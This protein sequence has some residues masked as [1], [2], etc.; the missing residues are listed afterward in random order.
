MASIATPVATERRAVDAALLF[1]AVF[2][3]ALALTIGL[4]LPGF[5]HH[6]T[7][8]AVMWAQGGWEAGFWKHPPF[9]PW[10]LRA[11]SS[12]APISAMSLSVLTAIN[13]TVC[14]WAVWMIAGMAV[15][16]TLRQVGSLAVLLLAALPFVSGM[17]IKLNHNSI[18]ISLWPLTTLAFLR[19]LDQP[20]ALRGALFGL[21]AAA[22]MLAKYYSGL[23]LA[24]CVVA[25]FATPWRARRF[26]A[27]PAP[28]VAIV[29]FVLAMAPHLAWLLQHR[30]TSL[31]YA[32]GASTGEIASAKRGPGMVLPFAVQTPLIAA[33][34]LV[35]AWLFRRFGAPSEVS[36]TPHRFEREIVILTLLP[37]VLTI[38]LTLGFNLRGAIAWAMPVFACLPA[39][40]AARIGALSETTL[41]NAAWIAAGLLIATIAVGQIALR[42]AVARGADGISDPRRKIAELATSAWHGATG[43]PLTIVAGDPRLSSASVVFSPDHPLGWPSFNEAQAP[44]IDKAAVMRDGF[45]ALCRAADASCLAA[46]AQRGGG[47]ELRCPLKRRITHLGA[48]GPWF[49]AV[50]VLIPPAGADK[51]ATAACPPDKP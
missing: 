4:R 13:M 28:Y 38:A 50:V 32:F 19:A 24:G 21:I 22:A 31:T 51:P 1:A 37:Y 17:A 12:A 48:V 47:R 25:S 45:V 11:W 27:A 15:E 5:V 41:K 18:L 3:G 14:A 33:P 40:L 7:T 42:T 8:E 44:W 2:C 36:P 49:E 23:L 16:R 10:V 34:M 9:L 43:R 6:D 20:T 46:A 39:V 26:Y 35:A 30:A 29:I